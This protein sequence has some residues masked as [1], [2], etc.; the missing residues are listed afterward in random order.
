[1]ALPDTLALPWPLFVHCNI[2]G[3]FLAP[4]SNL[5]KIHQIIKGHTEL[6]YA[7]G[8][9]V[10]IGPKEIS[11]GN[12]DGVKHST[13]SRMPK[14]SWYQVLQYPGLPLHQPDIGD[15]PRRHTE[16]GKNVA[17]GYALWNIIKSAGYLGELAL[18][19]VRGFTGTKRRRVQVHLDKWFNFFLFNIVGEVTFSHSF[20]FVCSGY[21][22][23]SLLLHTCLAAIESRKRNPEA[24]SD[25]MEQWL[26]DRNTQPDRMAEEEVFA[27]AAA[28]VGAEADVVSSSLQAL[29]YYLLRNM[30]YLRGGGVVKY[31]EEM[32]LPY[33]RARMG[34]YQY[35]SS[36][37]TNIPRAV[38]REGIPFSTSTTVLVNH[39]TPGIFGTDSISFN[40]AYKHGLNRGKLG[41]G[42]NYCPGRNLAHFQIS[43]LAA[44]LLQ[45]YESE[46][47]DPAREWV[48]KNQFITTLWPC[49][50][51]RRTAV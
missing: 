20:G 21:I 12:F 38:P 7:T 4:V 5:W 33:L 47:A 19:P 9:F 16:K 40:P 43:K 8:G 34:A 25:M 6:R 45:D 49:W 29:I 10:R 28:N 27:A 35:H 1:M 30:V 36:N 11:I 37:G 48:F 24:G 13:R 15:D 50:V 18:G 44:T 22:P 17:T 26:S 2:S 32:G 23:T 42:Y 3:L 39:R 31:L 14:G 51:R 46:R 41:A